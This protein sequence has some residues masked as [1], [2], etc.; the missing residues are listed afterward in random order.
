MSPEAGQRCNSDGRSPG[1]RLIAPGSGG[2][3]APLKSQA[4]SNSNVKALAPS[5]HRCQRISTP[6]VNWSS[7][8]PAP[9]AHRTER[10]APDRKAGGSI[11]SRRT[12][13]LSQDMVDTCC[14]TCGQ[15]TAPR[16]LVAA[17]WSRVRAHESSP[18]SVMMETSGPAMSRRT[19]RSLCTAPTGIVSEP[20]EVAEVPCRRSRGSRGALSGD[21]RRSAAGVVTRLSQLVA[22]P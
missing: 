18:S 17:S 15:A 22:H 21:E 8:L 10:A 5:A 19:L 7:R 14:K 16:G 4:T 9:V 20:A 13:V 1:W 11:P 2:G 12:L 6:R 3:A